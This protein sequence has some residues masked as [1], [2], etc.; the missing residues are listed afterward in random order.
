VRPPDPDLFGKNG[1]INFLQNDFVW[2]APIRA[3]NKQ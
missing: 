2:S 3:Q 1:S